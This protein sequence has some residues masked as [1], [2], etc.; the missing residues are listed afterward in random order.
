MAFESPPMKYKKNDPTAGSE[1]E[2]TSEAYKSP[3]HP[4]C[5]QETEIIL[6]LFIWQQVIFSKWMIFK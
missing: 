4:E 5:I 3:C 2:K 1:S 6:F